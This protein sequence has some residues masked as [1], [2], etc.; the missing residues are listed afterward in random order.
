MVLR[1]GPGSRWLWCYALGRDGGGGRSDQLGDY[2][3]VGHIT[4]WL[5]GLSMTVAPA[6]SAMA[7]CAG[8]GIIRSSVAIRYQVGL[9][10]QAW[11]HSDRPSA[12]E[13]MR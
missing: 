2:L 3:W 7:C 13:V 12:R 6:R 4:E 1:A 8:G 11:P 10:R 9:D 5:P